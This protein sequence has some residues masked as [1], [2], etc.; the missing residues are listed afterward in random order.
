MQGYWDGQRDTL[1]KETVIEKYL[2]ALK[3]KSSCSSSEE[4][5]SYQEKLVAKRIAQDGV[6]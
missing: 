2:K 6:K 4:W 5:E 3:E 1:R